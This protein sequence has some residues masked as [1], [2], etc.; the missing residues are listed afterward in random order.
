MNIPNK[1]IIKSKIKK[2]TSKS[3]IKFIPFVLYN[4]IHKYL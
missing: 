1:D 3:N 4:L 2:Q